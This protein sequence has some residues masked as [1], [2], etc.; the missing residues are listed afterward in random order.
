MNAHS[1]HHVGNPFLEQSAPGMPVPSTSLIERFRRNEEAADLVQRVERGT[2]DGDPNEAFAAIMRGITSTTSALPVREN[3]DGEVHIL[4]PVETPLRNRLPRVPGPGGASAQWRVQTAFGA[5]LG[6]STTTSGTTNAANTLVVANARGFFVGETILVNSATSYGP[7]TAINYSTNVLSFASGPSLNSQTSGQTV[8][9]TSLFWP[10][11]GAATRIFYAETG[12]PVENTTT[13]VNKTAAFKLIG[14]MGSVTMFG[15][16]VGQNFFNQYEVEKRNCLYRAMLK[17]E[18]ALLHAD[19][20]ATTAP[21]GDGVS[22]LAFQGLIPFITAN[23]PSAQLQTSVGALTLDHL[24]QQLSRIWYQGGRGLYIMMNGSQ[25][26]GMTKLLTN[27]GNYRLIVAQDSSAKAG[28]RVA[29]IVHAVSG[30]EVPIM[31]HPF[32]PAG[33]ILYGAD[34]NQMGQPTAE[35]EALPQVQAPASAF[36]DGTF[37]GFYAQEIAPTASAPEVL[38]FKVGCYEVPKWK[39]TQVFATST[40]VTAPA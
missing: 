4:S 35:V 1:F 16:A 12:A 31:V 11:N 29:A 25:A 32:L 20:S 9:K 30:E 13:Y 39:N 40:G 5:G 38:A 24:Q 36:L 2:F 7:I 3:L 28:V 37:Q 26:E 22:A 19:S 23:A 8:I 21:W 14:D 10:E 15:M 17:E 33:M 34:R 27:S 18:Y 6:T